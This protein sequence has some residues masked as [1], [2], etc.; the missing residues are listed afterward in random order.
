MISILLIACVV[1]A[2]FVALRLTSSGVYEVQGSH[3]TIYVEPSSLWVAPCTN[4]TVN[5]RIRDVVDL[6]AWQFNMTFDPNLMQ[7]VSVAEGEFLRNVGVTTGLILGVNNTNGWIKAAC[8]LVGA[9]SGASGGCV[10]AYATFHCTSVGGSVLDLQDTKLLNSSRVSVTPPPNLG[11]ITGDGK[12]DLKDVYI[13]AKA[14]CSRVGDPRYNSTADLNSDGAVDIEDLIIVTLNYGHIYPPSNALQPQNNVIAHT[15]EDGYVAQSL[16]VDLG[17]ETFPPGTY[18]ATIMEE[19]ST[20]WY[21]NPFGW[22]TPIG[23]VVPD[24]QWGMAPGIITMVELFSGPATVGS[25]VVFTVDTY[26]GFW[27]NNT[28]TLGGLFYTENAIQPDGPLYDHAKVEYVNP[29]NPSEGYLIRFE[30]YW[31]C[32]DHDWNDMVVKLVPTSYW[33]KVK[34]EYRCETEVIYAQGIADNRYIPGMVS[35]WKFDEWTGTTAADSADLNLGN[36][37]T[38]YAPLPT[39]TTEC[40]VGRGFQGHGALDFTPNPTTPPAAGDYVEVPTSTNLDIN[41]EITIEAWIKPDAVDYY[42]TILS[43]YWN[44][45]YYLRIRDGRVEFEAG[46]TT[47]SDVLIAPNNWYHIAGTYDGTVQKI[48]VNGVLVKSEALSY[49]LPIG[50]TAQNLVIGAQTVSHELGFDGIIDEV[51][52]FNRALTRTEIQQ[53]YQNS[54]RGLQYWEGLPL[55]TLITTH[56]NV[57]NPNHG[58]WV[59]GTKYYVQVL[60]EE[61]PPPFLLGGHTLKNYTFT[62]PPNKG[63]EIDYDDVVS[64]P[65]DTTQ[66]PVPPYPYD[67]KGFVVLESPSQ[68][69]VNNKTVPLLPLEVVAV[70]NKKAVDIINKITFHLNFTPWPIDTLIGKLKFY[71]PYEL[72]VPLPWEPSNLTLEDVVKRELGL[73]PP[74][75]PEPEDIDIEIEETKTY[76]DFLEC[77]TK[78]RIVFMLYPGDYMVGRFLNQIWPPEERPYGFMWPHWFNQCITLEKVVKIPQLD[79]IMVPEEIVR[80]EIIIALLQS[81]VPVNRV[82]DIMARVEIDIIEVD[83]AEGVGASIDVEYIKPEIIDP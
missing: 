71:E 67:L 8:S 64:W 37:G 65:N 47:L 42:R 81:G 12:V 55:E 7:C 1:S 3:Q 14:Y 53:H 83:V 17:V 19:A 63:F 36:L 73:L 66:P 22:Y 28:M 35:Y 75:P 20:A 25:T 15:V 29:S 78:E 52:I 45:G 48:Y 51:A 21:I 40:K 79:E 54:L 10:L 76:F 44:V 39:W 46:W 50:V 4:F 33:Y 49:H 26:F 68:I 23:T 56:I 9:V 59:N 13:V 31:L 69:V 34:F 24:G 11:D 58:L 77:V 72:S 2:S 41:D 32:W 74:P 82:K 57:Y 6:Y 38:L 43:K 62:L 16:S 80:D 70:Y 5:V 30:D 18:K 61:N 60:R 27:L